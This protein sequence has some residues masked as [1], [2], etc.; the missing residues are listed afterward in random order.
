MNKKNEVI[1]ILCVVLF[2]IIGIYLTFFSSNT[3]K[4]DSKTKAYKIEIQES[5]DS[6]NNK[7][8]YPIYYFKVEGKRYTCTTKTGSSIAP[9]RNKNIVYYDSKN[10]EKCIT[11][12]EKTSSRIG[13]IICLGV[14]LL[15]LFLGFRKPKENLVNVNIKCHKN[16]KVKMSQFLVRWDRASHLFRI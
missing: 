8:Y 1:I 4:Y 15:V 9:N 10:P 12:Y 14:S 7:V 13:G 3:S 16:F 5:N 11:Q 6:D 2:G